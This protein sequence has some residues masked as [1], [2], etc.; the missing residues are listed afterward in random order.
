MKD[1]ER[2]HQRHA[3]TMNVNLLQFIVLLSHVTISPGLFA[4]ETFEPLLQPQPILTGQEL[5]EYT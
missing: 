5:V 3:K 1:R 2:E 4:E